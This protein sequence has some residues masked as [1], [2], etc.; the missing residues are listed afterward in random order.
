MAALPPCTTTVAGV[1]Y[2]LPEFCESEGTQFWMDG[3]V[4]CT[5]RANGGVGATLT[6]C[7][8][9]GALRW[10]NFLFFLRAMWDV[11]SHKPALVGIY[12][13]TQKFTR[14]MLHARGGP[15]PLEADANPPPQPVAQTLGVGPPRVGVGWTNF[16]GNHS[17]RRRGRIA[18]LS[19]TEAAKRTVPGS[20][21][22][23]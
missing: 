1:P 20:G 14:V 19:W 18:S 9:K 6:A 22:S 17:R 11:R 15:P 5:I 4:F 10:C 21:T 8:L 12:Q 13:R 23:H 3:S 7:N 16:G 2:Q